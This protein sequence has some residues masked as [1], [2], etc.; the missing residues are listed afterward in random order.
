[1]HNNQPVVLAYDLFFGGPR[2]SYFQFSI[3]SY[4]TFQIFAYNFCFLLW[5]CEY[6]NRPVRA[7]CLESWPNH[8]LLS[9][10][11]HAE[12]T[13]RNCCIIHVTWLSQHRLTLFNLHSAETNNK[14]WLDENENFSFSS[15]KYSGKNVQVVSYWLLLSFDI[16]V[17]F[18]M[19]NPSSKLLSRTIEDLL[20]HRYNV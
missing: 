8:I 4:W 2:S 14:Y 16:P 12:P 17:T 20:H 10:H 18:Q 13:S 6:F 19:K 9:E 15:T 1:M 7:S 3:K 5:Q 11:Q